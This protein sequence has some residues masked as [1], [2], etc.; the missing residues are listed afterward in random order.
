MRDAAVRLIP[1]VAFLLWLLSLNLRAATVSHLGGDQVFYGSDILA[2]GWMGPLIGQFGWFANLLLPLGLAF[3]L[4]ERGRSLY[5]VIGWSL[6]VLAANS[7]FWDRIPDD[8]GQNYIIKFEPGFYCWMIAVVSVGIYLIFAYWR[9][10]GIS[11][12]APQ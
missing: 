12:E 2:L 4:L 9:D 3:L 10:K 6:L 5:P 11:M 7:S 8:S 1:V